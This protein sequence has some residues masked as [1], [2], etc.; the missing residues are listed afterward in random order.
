MFV[1]RRLVSR[2]GPRLRSNACRESSAGA[3]ECGGE[4]SALASAW[5]GFDGVAAAT[6][7]AGTAAV[8]TLISLLLALFTDDSDSH[9]DLLR[10]PP[11]V[12]SIRDEMA[13]RFASP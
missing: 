12:A 10:R 11:V 8:T 3:L 7:A 5:Q 4:E 9:I 2:A 6:T 13:S 1:H